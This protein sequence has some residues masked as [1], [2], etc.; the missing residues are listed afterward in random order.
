MMMK[1]I[2][3]QELNE[4]NAQFEDEW[5]DAENERLQLEQMEREEY[6]NKCS[7]QA[8]HFAW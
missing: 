1:A 5:R 6:E 8:V 2:N 4:L 3:E 7:P